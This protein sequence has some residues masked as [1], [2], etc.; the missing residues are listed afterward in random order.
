[1]CKQFL[2]L[3]EQICLFPLKNWRYFLFMA[4][5]VVTSVSLPGLAVEGQSEQREEDY[6]ILIKRSPRVLFVNDDGT[7]SSHVISLLKMCELYDSNDDLARVVEKTQ[8]AWIS[9]IQGRGGVE[10]IDLRDSEARKRLLPLVESVASEMRLFDPREPQET[11][12][13]YAL[14]HGAFL[15]GVRDRIAR[16]VDAWKRGIRFHTIVGLTGERYLRKAEGE[17]DDI[18]A[19]CD[20]SRSPLPF[21]E[22]W[23]FPKDAKYETEYDM[24]KLVWEQVQIPADMAEKTKIVFVNAPKGDKARPSTG[25]TFRTWLSTMPES[26]RSLPQTAIAFSHT[27]VW[28]QQQLV[29][30]GALRETR[31][32]VDTTAPALTA[33]L[34]AQYADRLVSI[35]FDT[36]AKCLYEIHQSQKEPLP[37]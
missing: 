35:I 19:L 5:V 31:L 24:M 8:Q 36:V 4:A 20:S 26:E 18:K 17:P 22:G 7:V 37:K 15:D 27:L 14:W 6:E 11:Q 2:S 32:A 30:E 33:Q 29:A 10:R 1:M 3:R 16:A 25:D 21:K 34:R 9:C 13:D 23:E 12:Y 28:A